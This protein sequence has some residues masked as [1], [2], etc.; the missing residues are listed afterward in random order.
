MLRVVRPEGWLLTTGDPFRPDGSGDETEFE[1]FNRHP[2]VLLGVNE[3]IPTF[4]KLLRRSSR[5]RIG[6]MSDCSRHRFLERADNCCGGGDDTMLF[7]SG[8]SRSE[9]ACQ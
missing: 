9:I 3:S 7:E 2:D 5:T 6:S 8:H 1:V 4:G